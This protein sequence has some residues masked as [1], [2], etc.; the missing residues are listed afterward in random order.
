MVTLSRRKRVQASNKVESNNS[1]GSS[2]KDDARINSGG[3]W[4]RCR[5]GSPYSSGEFI[6]GANTLFH[7]YKYPRARL[8]LSV[9]IDASKSSK[10][11]VVVDDTDDEKESGYAFDNRHSV[12]PFLYIHSFLIELL[13]IAL[14]R[15]QL[16]CIYQSNG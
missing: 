12:F 4:P 5:A 1:S 10:E 7:S 14:F 13:C 11:E 9:F 8:P 15:F 2:K 3:T 6:G 16:S